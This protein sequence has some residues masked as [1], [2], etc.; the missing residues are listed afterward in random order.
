MVCAGIDDMV[1]VAFDKSR[2][3]QPLR[4]LSIIMYSAA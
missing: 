1:D 3:M 4:G 2:L